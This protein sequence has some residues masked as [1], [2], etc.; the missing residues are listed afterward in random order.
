MKR[1]TKIIVNILAIVM[2]MLSCF[3]LVACE[4]IRRIAITRA[5]EE[6]FPSK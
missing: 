1:F 5:L 4:D 2:L 6:V 3:G